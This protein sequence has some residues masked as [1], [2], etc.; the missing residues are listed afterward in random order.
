MLVAH[1]DEC[2]SSS[3]GVAV[4]VVRKQ[5]LEEQEQGRTL[6]LRL[7][8]AARL[9]VV[10]D[11]VDFGAFGARAVQIFYGCAVVEIVHGEVSFG[12]VAEMAGGGRGSALKAA[13]VEGIFEEISEEIC[14]AAVDSACEEKE[15]VAKE[16]FDAAEG[17][18]CEERDFVE[19]V[20]F[21]VVVESVDREGEV[22]DVLEVVIVVVIV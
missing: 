5:A 13:P 19:V 10:S 15:I 2:R 16:T 3:H 7:K 22:I 8:E 12:A 9:L 17:I 11:L 4:V 1:F 6:A 14:G 18:S 21:Y 20:I